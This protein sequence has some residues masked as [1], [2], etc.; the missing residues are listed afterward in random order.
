ML[1]WGTPR[2]GLPAEADGLRVVGPLLPCGLQLE[3][4]LDP[5]KIKPC[6]I[7][8]A[9]P[10]PHFRRERERRLNDGWQERR[11]LRHGGMGYAASRLMTKTLPLHHAE[12]VVHAGRPLQTMTFSQPDRSIIAAGLRIEAGSRDTSTLWNMY[13]IKSPHPKVKYTHT[14]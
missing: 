10:L 9:A 8:P 5:E 2:Q 14:L 1:H 3:V 11:L 7:V 13:Y 6:L 12:L 4:M